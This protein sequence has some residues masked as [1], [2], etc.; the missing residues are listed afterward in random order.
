MGFYEYLLISIIAITIILA[1]VLIYCIIF[2]MTVM[3]DIEIGLRMMRDSLRNLPASQINRDV[4]KFINNIIQK[5][6]I[7]GGY[8]IL[9]P[10]DAI[11]LIRIRND[12]DDANMILEYYQS[13]YKKL[14]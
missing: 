10:Q 8:N 7:D 1:I 3:K 2:S 5:Y 14:L 6:I 11:N 12:I 13:E 9:N 4:Y